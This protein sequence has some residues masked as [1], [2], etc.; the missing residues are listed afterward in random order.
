MIKTSHHLT[1]FTFINIANTSINLV[2]TTL[3]IIIDLKNDKSNVKVT[4]HLTLY[5]DENDEKNMIYMSTTFA[6]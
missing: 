3:F 6:I 2:D 1:I 5:L 4:L